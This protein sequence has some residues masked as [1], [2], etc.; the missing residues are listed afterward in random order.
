MDLIQWLFISNKSKLFLIILLLSSA[1][2]FSQLNSGNF[3]QFSEKDGLPGVQVNDVLVDRLGYVWTGTVNGLARYDGYGF[4]RF[5]FNPND[6][7]TVHGLIVW[8]LFE[9][10]KGHIWAGTSPSFL[11]EYDPV[12]QKFRQYLFTHLIKHPDNVELVVRSM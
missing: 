10:S 4:K 11:N 6:T 12:T 8:S 7:N 5:Y 9:D 1:H 2:S 3:T